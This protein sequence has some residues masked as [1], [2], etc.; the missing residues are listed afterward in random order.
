MILLIGADGAESS[1]G[2]EGTES[3][4][5]GSGADGAVDPF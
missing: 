5:I 1:A 3:S 4:R 2:A